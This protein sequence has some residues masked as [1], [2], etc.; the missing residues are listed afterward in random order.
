MLLRRT[1]VDVTW[2]NS[3][4][5]QLYSVTHKRDEDLTI[6]EDMEPGPY[7]HKPPLDDAN[8]ERLEPHSGIR[9]LYVCLHDSIPTTLII[10]VFIS[11]P[12][13]RADHAR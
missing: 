5:Q 6:I 2:S 13:L 11:H 9:L 1:L 12:L 8:F 7:E 3:K 10:D 4:C